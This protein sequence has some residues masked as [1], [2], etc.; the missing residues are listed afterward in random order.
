[1]QSEFSCEQCRGQLV[2][3]V[4]NSASVLQKQLIDHHLAQCDD[5]NDSLQQL[6]QAQSLATRWDEENVP[7]WPRREIF[8]GSLRWWPNVQIASTFMTFLVL[9]FV[10]ADARVSLEN[11]LSISFGRDLYMTQDEFNHRVSSL[12]TELLA[13]QRNQLQTNVT[14]LATQQSATNQLLLRT[15]LERSR[16]ERHDELDTLMTTWDLVQNQQS[17]QTRENM[18][19]LVDDQVETRRNVEQLNRALS[20]AVFEGSNL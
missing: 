6:W 9:V 20:K 2:D 18:R 16:E 17:K 7:C 12:Q 8:F 1:M 15:I 5:C 14:N 19:T 13:Q 3:L 11:G 4:D 10:L